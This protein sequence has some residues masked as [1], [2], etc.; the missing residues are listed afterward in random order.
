[1][2]VHIAN[3]LRRDIMAAM[4]HFRPDVAHFRPGISH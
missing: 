1:M 2:A 4:L 3:I